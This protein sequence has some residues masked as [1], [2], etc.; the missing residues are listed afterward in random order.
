[1]T[2]FFFF[3]SAIFCNVWSASIKLYR[4][5]GEAR[6]QQSVGH[7]RLQ[8]QQRRSSRAAVSQSPKTTGAAEKLKAEQQSVTSQQKTCGKCTREGQEKSDTKNSL[9]DGVGA[10]PVE[11]ESFP[12]FDRKMFST[13]ERFHKLSTTMLTPAVPVPI[14]L[15]GLS[16]MILMGVVFFH[17]LSKA[18][19]Q[20]GT[21]FPHHHYICLHA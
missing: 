9:Q 5:S 10:F 12:H 14:L 18:N 21:Y 13:H 11:T 6:E 2:F 17:N 16:V 19:G 4:C 7:Q 3:F 15:Q 20:P 8:L 1:M